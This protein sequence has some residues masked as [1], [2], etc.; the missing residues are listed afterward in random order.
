MKEVFLKKAGFL[1]E[2]V[3]A[4]KTKFPL[5]VFIALRITTMIVILLFIVV[6]V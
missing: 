6:N 5:A 3:N 4:F 1:I 2:K